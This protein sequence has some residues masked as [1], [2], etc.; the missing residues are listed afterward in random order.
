MDAEAAGTCPSSRRRGAREGV[1][2]F[3]RAW[4]EL[5]LAEPYRLFFPLA[6]LIGISGVSLWP[7]FFSGIHKFYPGLMH[8]RM[9]IEGFMGGFIIGFLGTAMPRLLSAPPLCGWEIAVA[10]VLYLAATGLHIG[11]Q[12]LPGDLTFAALLL[13]FAI[14][15]IRR[16]PRGAELP[17]PSFA[18]VGM[19]YLSGL[20]GVLLYSAGTQ[21]WVSGEWTMIGSAWLN[22][23]FVAL[24]VLGVGGFLLPRFLRIKGLASLDEERKPTGP[25][26]KRALFSAAIGVAILGSYVWQWMA[27]TSRGPSILRVAAV[28]TFIVVL[29][30]VHRGSGWRH[31]VP[32]AVI[33]SLSALIWGLAFPLMAEAQ[34]VAGL[35]IVFLAGF[36]VITMT[37]ATRVVLGHSGN[38]KMFESKLPSLRI[39]VAFLLIGTVLRVWGD[40]SAA[41]SSILSGASYLW[42]AA[43]IIWGGAILPKV[44]VPG[45]DD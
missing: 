41:R 1:R 3:S 19:G 25:W 18:L 2:I 39:A 21:G 17:P 35:H 26:R 45:T 36:S 33:V 43:A 5:C 42:M 32:Q 44:R 16:V 22:E 30:P 10:S 7:L 12:V 28:A 34:R 13:F 23:A 8:G 37:V 4:L 15:M 27:Y 31:I 14:S 11:H 20:A 38:G 6:T 24:L 9:M 29:V 40:F